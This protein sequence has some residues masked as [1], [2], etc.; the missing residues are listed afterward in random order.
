MKVSDTHIP[1]VK[2]IHQFR[3]DDARG[4]FVKTF[5]DSGLR[6]AG[7]HFE[8]KE[9]FYSV[10]RADVIR[11]LHFQHP[12]Y[13]H[14]KVVFCTSGAILDVALDIRKHSPTYGNFVT[15]ELSAQNNHALYIP[16]GFAHGFKTLVEDTTTFYFV[17]S[18]NH[19]PADD[20]IL[21]SSIRMDW[22][23]KDPIVSPRDLSFVSF[24]QFQSPF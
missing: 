18:E 4:H 5:H 11:G 19:R 10:S 24:D 17:S 7:I 15:A 1:D 16:R 20:G 3:A 21:Y 2:L 13:D 8:M 9:S 14:A 6:E 12:P 23:V 22:D